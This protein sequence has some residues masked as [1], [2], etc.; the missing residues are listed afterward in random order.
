MLARVQAPAACHVPSPSAP[1]AVHVEQQRMWPLHVTLSAVTH[2]FSLQSL[3]DLKPSE[4]QRNY[5]TRSSRSRCALSDPA[6][7]NHGKRG[8]ASHHMLTVLSVQFLQCN[9]TDTLQ[10][11]HEWLS[12][13]YHQASKTPPRHALVRI[14]EQVPAIPRGSYLVTCLLT[15]R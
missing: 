6:H 7:C 14:C 1:F 8:N 4:V 10:R 13:R 15:Q 9:P 2:L 5:R 12:A 11:V 3:S